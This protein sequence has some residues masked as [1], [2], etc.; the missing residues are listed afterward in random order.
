MVSP[1]GEARA[2]AR[3]TERVTPGQAFLSFHFPETGTNRLISR[4]LDRVADCPEYKVTPV[5]IERCVTAEEEPCP[6][7]PT[8]SRS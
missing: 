5:R 1:F 4:V 6:R 3:V 8:S 7:P 2:V